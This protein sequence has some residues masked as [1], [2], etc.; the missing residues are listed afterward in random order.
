MGLM[1]LMMTDRGVD[2]AVTGA[3]GRTDEGVDGD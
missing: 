3:D 1:G 2:G